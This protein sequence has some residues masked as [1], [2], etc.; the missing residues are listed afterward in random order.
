MDRMRLFKRGRE[1]EHMA[2]QRVPNEAE[3]DRQALQKRPLKAIRPEEPRAVETQEE[4]PQATLDQANCGILFARLCIAFACSSS[5]STE[6]TKGYILYNNSR[7]TFIA[8][9]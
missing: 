2:T 9:F 7:S 1:S 4:L 3:T 6:K 8:L 5:S